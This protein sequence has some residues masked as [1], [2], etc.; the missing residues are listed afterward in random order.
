LNNKNPYRFNNI[1]MM[2]KVVVETLL[3]ATTSSGGELAKVTGPGPGSAADEAA[4]EDEEKYV[5]A[6]PPGRVQ[7]DAW[8]GTEISTEVYAKADYPNEAMEKPGR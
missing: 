6:F 3:K 2:L 4:E 5:R 1:I 8:R 7:E